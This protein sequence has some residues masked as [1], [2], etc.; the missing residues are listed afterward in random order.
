MGP[1]REQILIC[2]CLQA[3]GSLGGTGLVIAESLQFKNLRIPDGRDR[4]ALSN[5]GFR[6]P[7]GE[8][9][10]YP[11]HVKNGGLVS[12]V[13]R[14]GL[15]NSVVKAIRGQ[16]RGVRASVIPLPGR[17]KPQWEVGLNQTTEEGVV[18]TNASVR[19]LSWVVDLE[20]KSLRRSLCPCP[21]TGSRHLYQDRLQISLQLAPRLQ[22]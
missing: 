12:S 15:R 19:G 5:L 14:L 13:G 7:S 8:I 20:T 9:C 11:I 17:T 18:L 16:R 4:P 10:S 1:L 22:R 21:L 3:L 6:V 2:R